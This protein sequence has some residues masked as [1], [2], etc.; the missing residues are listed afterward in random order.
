[1]K[2]AKKT[3]FAEF[4]DLLND[5]EGSVQQAALQ[6]L[7]ELSD[8][9]DSETRSFI[10]IPAWKKIC[11]SNNPKLSLTTAEYLGPFMWKARG[12]AFGF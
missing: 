11:A 4:M 7:M 9:F 1:M 2:L 8:I 3:V 10:L 6:S 5:E 12:I